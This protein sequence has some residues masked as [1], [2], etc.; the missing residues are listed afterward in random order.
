MSPGGI[1]TTIFDQRTSRLLTLF[2]CY[3]CWPIICHLLHGPHSY[4]ALNIVC[5]NP[6]TKSE[7]ATLTVTNIMIVKKGG[8]F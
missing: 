1:H 7:I 4:Q 2:K 6:Q 8:I 3:Y 5:A